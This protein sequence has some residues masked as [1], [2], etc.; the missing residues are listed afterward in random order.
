MLLTKQCKL[1]LKRA[2]RVAQASAPGSR[3]LQCPLV[4]AGDVIS[5]HYWS[6][7]AR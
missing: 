1:P 3:K 4:T 5:G 6:D 2:E 7:N